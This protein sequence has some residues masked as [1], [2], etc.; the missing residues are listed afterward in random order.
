MPTSLRRI[1]TPMR[2]AMLCIAS[3]PFAFDLLFVDNRLE[4]IWYVHLGGVF[5][6]AYYVGLR[7]GLAIAALSA[8]ARLAWEWF[9]WKRVEGDPLFSETW[10]WIANESLFLLLAACIALLT[11]KL[12]EK[13]QE[14]EDIFNSLD[15]TIWS[16]DLRKDAIVIS[17]GVES[18]YGY[19]GRQFAQDPSLWNRVVY[20]A[21]A[22]VADEMNA[23]ALSGNRTNTE[24]RIVRPDGHVRWI[25]DK[26]TPIFDRN[27]KLV[28]VNGVV[29]DITERKLAEEQIRKQAYYDYL[30]DLPNR[31]FVQDR[32]HALLQRSPERVAVAFMDLDGFKAVNDTLGHDAGDA[33]LQ[34]VSRRM[35]ARLRPGDALGRLGG[36][37]FLAVMEGAEPSAVAAVAQ[38]IIDAVSRPYDIQGRRAVITL[39]MGISMY[40][41]DGETI[42]ALT[43][44]ADQAMYLAKTSGK[45][46]YCFFGGE[47]DA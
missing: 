30:T 33:I 43:K 13:R 24:F 15:A 18:I 32:L 11:D 7:A 14:M 29:I 44:R 27:G 16:H 12:R 41:E 3:I 36:D 46:R 38:G 2:W 17:A 5:A 20:P 28:R 42:E 45:N 39:S 21:D 47:K 23:R 40:P 6:A 8:A 1:P 37:E 19:T 26:S 4:T 31:K 9:E 34:E 22:A 25:Q 10:I 35:R